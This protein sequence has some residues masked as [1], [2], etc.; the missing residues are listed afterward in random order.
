MTSTSRRLTKFLA[1]LF[2]GLIWAG[3]ASATCGSGGGT[4]FWIGGTGTLNLSSDSAHWSA[5]SGSTTC[6]CEPASTD[7]WTFDG[8]SGGGTV[9]FAGGGGT[10]TAGAFTCGNYT[11]TLDNSVNNNTVNITS[12]SCTGGATKTLKSGSGTWHLTGTTGT[13]LDFTTASN[14]TFGTTMNLAFD[15]VTATG[16]RTWIPSGKTFASVSFASASATA[17]FPIAVASPG[18]A[19]IT[20]ATITAPVMLSWL[21]GS[22]V[23]ITNAIAWNGSSGN[24]INL[25]AT[26]SGSAATLALTGGGS[27][28]WAALRDIN[29]TT[30][31]PTFSNSFDMRGNGGSAPATINPPGASTGGGHVF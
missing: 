8:S 26:T 11:G 21:S 20:T 28:S 4:C 15:A 22:T 6:S 24:Y 5:N 19:T 16:I 3:A 30:S 2:V 18:T 23:T 17:D 31:A 25:I 29:F 7:A 9:T 27:G 13:L 1:A 10:L 12:L 14:L